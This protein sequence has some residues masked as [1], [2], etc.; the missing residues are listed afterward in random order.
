LKNLRLSFEKKIASF[1]ILVVLV[2]TCII[3]IY[4]KITKQAQANRKRVTHTENVLALCDSIKLNE[5]KVVIDTRTYLITGNEYSLKSYTK[6]KQN[7]QD[8]LAEIKLSLTENPRQAKRL[9]SIQLLYNQSNQLRQQAI[10]NRKQQN[11]Q[12]ASVVSFINAIDSTLINM[13]SVLYS[14]KNEE[15]QLLTQRR[16][17]DQANMQKSVLLI[18]ILLLVFILS[19]LSAFII[20]YRNTLLRNKA[21]KALH[22]SKGLIDSIINHAPVLVS[23]KDLTGKYITVNKQTADVLNTTPE[24][25][26][27]KKNYAF[28]DIE[29]A[30]RITK[31][32]EEVLRSGQ[33]SEMQVKMHKPDGLHTYIT[34]KFPLFDI[35]GKLYAIGSTSADITPVKR[36]HEALEESYEQQ[37]KVLNGLQQAFSASSDLICIINE[38]GEFVMLTD[39]VQELLGYTAKELMHKKFMNYVVEVDR[40]KTETIAGEIMSGKSVADFTNRYRKKDGSVV[41]IIWTATW[42]AGDRVMYCI[43]RNGTERQKTAEQLVQSQSSLM[44]AQRIARLGNWEWDIKN[45]KLYCSDEMYRLIGQPKEEVE[46]L[47]DVFFVA[48]HPDDRQLIQK[49]GEE[50]LLLG[51]KLEIEHRVVQPDGTT[52]FMHTRGEVL[53]DETHEPTWISGT[54]QDITGRKKAEDAI[55]DSEEKRKLIMNAAQD[56]IICIDIKNEIIFWNPQAERIFGWKEKEVM[57]KDLAETIIPL[58]LREMHIKGMKHYANTGEAPAMNKLL[59]MCA[60]NKEGKEFPVEITILPIKQGGE[61]FFCSFIR[62]ISERKQSEILLKELN[63]NLKKRAEELQTSNTELERFAY[64]A[65]H[66]LQEPVRMVSSFLGLLKKKLNGSLDDQSKQF[67]HFAVDGAERMKRLI[68]DLL[69]FSRL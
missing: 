4:Q 16:E 51:K 18:R 29:T 27:G 33:P 9:D 58:R 5:Q 49:A 43:A 11:F 30:D 8:N 35:D 24:E 61:E 19:I 36:A 56:A 23:V 21:E 44:H 32:E 63:L 38:D 67:I 25:M 26:I 64:V 66:D 45:N 59:E 7:F 14:I 17:N 39:T 15:K 46:S 28:L 68:Q 34:S 52:C 3:F 65:S 55:K 10:H 1:F 53:F 2:I 47:Q 54:M 62:D 37:Q 57:N 50:S 42:V 12:L 60:I 20:V 6:S 69:L 22:H 40:L 13:H 31:E 48:V 41:P